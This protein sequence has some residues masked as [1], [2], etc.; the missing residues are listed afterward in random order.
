MSRRHLLVALSSVPLTLAW[1][2]IPSHVHASAGVAV[3]QVID[4]RKNPEKIPPHVAW[5]HVFRQVVDV[6]FEPDGAIN[7]RHVRALGSYNIGIS[8]ADARVL[9]EIAKAT[10]TKVD[11]LRWWELVQ[12]MTRMLK[13]A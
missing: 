9:A 6:A 11:G 5:E 3:A 4:G 12:A 2:A 1:V 8:A 7:E 10:I 13:R